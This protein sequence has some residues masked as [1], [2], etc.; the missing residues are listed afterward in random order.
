M[1]A[2]RFSLF[3]PAV[4]EPEHDAPAPDRLISGDPKFRTWNL[5]DR[6]GKLFAGVWEATPGKWHIAY[7]EWEFVHVLKGVSVITEK[8]GE[9]R[10]VKAGDSFIIRP[11]FIGTWEVIETTLKEYVITL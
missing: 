2:P 4:M 8:D 6:D 5:E 9:A 7:E 11:G 10:T 3:N 1:S